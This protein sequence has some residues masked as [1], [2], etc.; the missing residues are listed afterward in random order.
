MVGPLILKGPATPVWDPG[1]VPF[2]VLDAGYLGSF[3]E[4]ALALMIW[5]IDF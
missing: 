5:L 1:S 3:L 4:E 2:Q